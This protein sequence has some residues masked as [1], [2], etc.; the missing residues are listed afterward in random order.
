[1]TCRQLAELL[2]DFVSDELPPE[3]RALLEHHLS[4]CP[5]CLNYLESYQVTIKLTR[6]LPCV[7]PPPELI[8]K[9]RKVLEEENKSE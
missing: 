7:P 5:P 9:L 8:E 2:I 4:K 6:R 3:R 1:M